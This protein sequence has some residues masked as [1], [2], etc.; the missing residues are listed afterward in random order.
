MEKHTKQ[1][2]VV[3]AILAWYTRYGRTL[4]WRNI[5]DPY[6]IL[7]SEIM[8]QQTQVSRVLEKFPQFLRRFPTL[9]SLANAPRR[10]VILAWRGMGYNNR[11]V[12]LHECARIIANNHRGRIPDRLD[13]LL[14]L[15]GI[16]VYTAHA[17]LCSVHA[18]PVP[19]VD[20]NVQRV[21]SR[22]FWRMASLDSVRAA[23]EIATLAST[24][25]PKHRAYEWNQ[26][27][28]DLGAT[29]C[30]ALNPRCE[31]CPVARWC[32]S[33]TR[34]T[35]PVLRRSQRRRPLHDLPDRIYRGRIIERLRDTNG[36]RRLRADA[37]AR[38]IHPTFSQHQ[39]EWFKRL[40]TDLQRDGLLCVS[41]NGRLSSMYVSLP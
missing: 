27:V 14:E 26:A 39:E 1:R 11:A 12:R 31:E 29:V 35:R 30:T 13:Q 3:R 34:M 8:L 37:V 15:P 9:R 41:G 16:G 2:N 10:E 33:C 4:P 19:V 6:R 38:S 24:L 17:L 28:M 23:A 36:A 21:L 5:A 18:R 22:I 40:L 7:V 25:L 20:V 32:S